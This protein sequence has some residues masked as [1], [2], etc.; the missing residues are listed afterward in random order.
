M[1]VTCSTNVELQKQT[2]NRALFIYLVAWFHFFFLITQTIPLNTPQKC[3]SW[4]ILNLRIIIL[5]L[6]TSHYYRLAQLSLQICSVFKKLSMH[7]FFFAIIA[8]EKVFSLKEA[9]R[10]MW[11]VFKD[12]NCAVI[13]WLPP[14]YPSLMEWDSGAVSFT[15]QMNWVSH[16]NCY[17][18]IS[19]LL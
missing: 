3:Y 8:F 15:V 18:C 14:A 9:H 4:K 12:L 2:P 10:G 19:I 5:L 11:N 16:D 6:I 13:M 17:C 7:I 1:L